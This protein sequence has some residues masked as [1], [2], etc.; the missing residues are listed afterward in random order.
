MDMTFKPYKKQIG[1][2]HYKNMIMQPSE[3]IN[4]NRLPFAEGSAIKYI[5][6]HAAKGK[7]QDIE[8]AIHYLE[9]ILERDYEDRNQLTSKV[10]S[11]HRRTQREVRQKNHTAKHH[12]KETRKI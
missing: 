4:K 8:K 9:M 11:N 10:T 7:E 6:R 2:S 3:F 1:G 12:K 5:C